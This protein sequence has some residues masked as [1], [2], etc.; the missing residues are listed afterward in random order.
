[1]NSQVYLPAPVNTVAS[2]AVTSVVVSETPPH[3]FPITDV[4]IFWT[5][6]FAL[7][8]TSIDSGSSPRWIR[9]AID[10]GI[11]GIDVLF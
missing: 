8:K 2:I 11:A 3:L 4:V 5:R 10:R 9:V 7:V 6:V 1:M